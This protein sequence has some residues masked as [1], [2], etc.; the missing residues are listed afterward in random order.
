[1][2]SWWLRGVLNFPWLPIGNV[3]P[4][5]TRA[6]PFL[7][8]HRFR[9]P[10]ERLASHLLSCTGIPVR[11]SRPCGSCFP[12]AINMFAMLGTRLNPLWLLAAGGAAG[13]LGFLA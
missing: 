8:F 2:D 10:F 5:Q 13:G 9:Y 7:P 6:L 3:I 4:Q 1:M 11:Y 12:A